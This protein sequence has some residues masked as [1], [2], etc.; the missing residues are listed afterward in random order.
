M[1]K[2]YTSVRRIFWAVFILASCQA[3]AFSN[4]FYDFEVTV[5]D[6]RGS[7]MSGVNVFTDDQKKVATT[8]DEN[9][10]AI[11]TD[12][13]HQDL[14]NFTFIGYV[15]LKLP[16]FEIR[17]RNGIVRM[18]RAVTELAQ[19]VVIGRRDDLPSQ[20]PFTFDKVTKEDI[21]KFESQT[22]ADALWNSAGVFVQKTQMGGGSPVLRGF[23]ANR[24]LLVVDG[25]RMNTGIYR[26]G[27]LQNSITIDNAMLERTEV[28]MGPGSLLYGSDA[29]GGV[30][31]FRSR[32]PQLSFDETPGSYNMQ[33]N[34]YTRYAS[35]NRE[36]SVHADVNYGRRN[37]ASL[38]SLTYTDY[39]NLR[40]GA[41]RPDGYEDFGKRSYYV[42]RVGN[43]DQVLENPDYNL[44][45][46]TAY[47]QIDILQKIKFQPNRNFYTVLNF[48]HSTSTDIPRYDF[49]TE[50]TNP[51]DPTSFRYAEWFY[52][53][54]RR[55]M[56][57]LKSR[58]SK[59]TPIYDRATLIAAFQRVHENRLNRILHKSQ[60]IFQLENVYA[61]SLTAD[62]DKNLSESGRS[63]LMYGLDGNFN[64]VYSESGRVKINDESL[65]KN[66]LSRYPAN[67]DVLSLAAYTNYQ[68][69]TADTAFTVSAGLR[70]NWVKLHSVFS[71][72]SIIVWPANFL[73]PGTTATNSD[74]T[75]SLGA[76]WRSPKG[77]EVR[78][79]AS[80]AFRSPNIDDYSQFR[81]RN[82]FI[83]IPNPD[84]Q[85]ERSYNGE[86]SLGHEIGR[87]KTQGLRIRL[88]LTGYYTLVKGLMTRRAFDLPEGGNLVEVDGQ[89]Y[90]TR[91]NVN[92]NKGIIYGWEGRLQGRL[93]KNWELESSLSFV[94]G[95]ASLEAKDELGNVIFDTLAPIDHIPP[96]HGFTSL[97]FQTDK[98]RLSA[99]ARYQAQ[100]PIERYGASGVT[101][102]A[103]GNAILDRSGTEDNLEYSY[104]RIE[105]NGKA[106]YD[107]TL[108]WTTWNAY[109]SYNLTK[110]L[111][112]N[113]AVENILDSHYRP[114]SS[115][116]SAAG[117]NFI[118]SLR[119]NLSK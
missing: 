47:A 104:Y 87:N 17:K 54:Q 90:E 50:L 21:A 13:G 64:K 69:Q 109:G 89:L 117:R 7:P 42:E 116:V 85:P 51:A 55:L 83:S 29:L 46:G 74:L 36:K 100:K 1:F 8:T 118:V 39:D 110:W 66:A 65:T 63:K 88:D 4:P 25:V 81:P 53:P 101:L 112:V 6:E 2:R 45:V 76:T 48:Q 20:V 10:K 11:L 16:F 78:A 43:G 56:A 40:A 19:V 111:T 5:L 67:N 75:W 34:L 102:D 68:W 59:K 86:L 37:W 73:D 23:E 44:Q 57:S 107:G 18:A 105:E 12:L 28:I 91:A 97:T 96:M 80:K 95:D 61:Y 49:L 30:I 72:D 26:S 3:F 22:A 38:T 58:F 15:P 9:G 103:E 113:M 99:V 24:V 106:V 62:F 115:G 35:A 71:A 60:R 92:A 27:H 84:L 114:F 93:G 33:G 82:N 77:T 52:G 41:N 31:H 79:L 32:D 98:F 119:V 70:Y 108:A 94:H 14:V